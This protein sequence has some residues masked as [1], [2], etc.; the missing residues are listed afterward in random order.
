MLGEIE[1]R[2]Q[3]LLEKGGAAR[4]VDK[5]GDSGEVMKLVE[6]LRDAITRY[7]VSEDRFVASNRTY[8]A[9]QV[10]QQQAIYDKQQATYEQIT[11]LTV[12]TLRLV[13]ILYTDDRTCHQVF[14][15]HPLEDSRGDADQ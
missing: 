6:Q 15:Q 4:F 8:T 13:F 3:A 11:N 1:K 7:Q 9:G 12:R 5:G 10:S 2:S 14:F